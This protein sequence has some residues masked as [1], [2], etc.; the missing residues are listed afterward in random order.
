MI[1][2]T[3]DPLET[4]LDISLNRETIDQLYRTLMK[5][6]SCISIHNPLYEFNINLMKKIN[7]SLN[8]D[9][10]WVTK[11]DWFKNRDY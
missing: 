11:E 6:N 3:I 9:M 4:Q 8:R 7:T 5:S 1:R 2:V 10:S